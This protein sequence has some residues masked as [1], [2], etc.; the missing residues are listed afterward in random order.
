ME[1]NVYKGSKTD[2]SYFVTMTLQNRMPWKMLSSNLFNLAPTLNETK[3]IILILLKELETLHLI[4]QKKDQELS[5]YQS[6]SFTAEIQISNIEH[7]N[8]TLE[9]E[10]TTDEIQENHQK[11][12]TPETETIED[13]IEILEVVKESMNEEILLGMKKVQN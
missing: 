2:F 3:E 6:S 1:S 13:K 12:S 9:T 5:K 4:L 7:Q 10:I 8:K 11:S